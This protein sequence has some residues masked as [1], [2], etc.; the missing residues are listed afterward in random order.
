[1]QIFAFPKQYE[2]KQLQA[3]EMTLTWILA[4][5]IAG[6]W[7]KSLR[8][9]TVESASFTFLIFYPNIFQHRHRF[10]ISGTNFFLLYLNILCSLLLSDNRGM[11][12]KCSGTCIVCLNSGWIPLFSFPAVMQKK[13]IIPSSVNS[14]HT[15]SRPFSNH[16]ATSRRKHT[17]NYSFTS[18]VKLP[19]G[20][21][22]RG[23]VNH[24]GK[25]GNVFLESI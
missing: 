12:D 8:N 18:S 2:Q 9:L 17:K 24:S 11:S 19:P 25:S 7:L 6:L 20:T 23:N 22:F 1:M 5:Y 13:E 16:H 14:W 21:C 10:S 4:L 15:R 3:F